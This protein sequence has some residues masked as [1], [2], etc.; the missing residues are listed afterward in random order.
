MSIAETGVPGKG[1]RF[2][3]SVPND[4]YQMRKGASEEA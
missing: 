4:R 2:E 1:A 3:I